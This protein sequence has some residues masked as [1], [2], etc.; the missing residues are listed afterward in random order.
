MKKIVLSIF[1][2]FLFC[3]VKSAQLAGLMDVKEYKLSN[4]M[5]VWLN[6]D[7]LQ[8]KIFGAVLVKAGSKDCPNTGI[9]H[10]FEHMMFKG[11]DRIGTVNYPAEKVLLD[12]IAVKYDE[13][14][15]TKDEASRKHLQQE[16][17]T[18]S[19]HA[20][21]FAIPNEFN[22]LISRF[23]GSNL[24]AGTSFDYTVYYN[25]F[26]PQY[27]NQWAEL[28]SER[29]LN[30]VF[31]L[32]QSE[33]ETVYEEKNMGD[34]MIG[35]QAMDKILERFFKPNPYA[36]PI[37]GSSENLKNPQLSQMRNFFEEYYVAGNMGL[38]LS[39][40]FNTAEILPVLEKTFSRIRSGD[41]P[42][43]KSIDPE[44]FKGVETFTVKYPVPVIK[45]VGIGWRGAPANNA[46]EV[47][48]R[49]ITGLLNNEN[50]TGYL[51]KLTVDGKVMMA[52]AF[53][54]SL[55][56]A[57]VVCVAAIP[58]I[59][60][61]SVSQAKKRIMAE[62]KR[63][64]NGDFT[65]ESFNSLKLEQLRNCEKELENIDSRSQKMLSLFSQGK[66][67]NDY[68]DEIQKI[69]SLTKDDVVKVANKYFTENYL[70]VKKKTGTYPKN[71]LQKPAFAPII[72]KN[73]EVK[74]EY[75]RNLEKMETLKAH[76]RYLDF[77][78]D[79]KRVQLTSMA[80]LY[81]MINPVNDIFTLNLEFGKG[82]MESK[83]AK[84]AG[85]YLSLLGTD[86]LS[87][88]QFREK[89]QNLGSTL[90]F[91]PK[92]D[93]F[94]VQIS[95]FD[96]N[97]VQTLSLVGN[98]MKHVKADPKKLKKVVEIMKVNAKTEKKS[99][100]VLANA[101]LDKVRYGNQSEYLNRLSLSEFQKLK[102]QDL[103]DEFMAITKVQCDIHYCGNLN[104]ETVA[105]EIRKNFA[106]EE[107]S[108]KSQ[109]PVYLEPKIN[110]MPTVYFMDDP[111]SSQSIVSEYIPGKIDPDKVSRY[112][113]SLF[114]H[115]F[116][117]N[118]SSIL[119][120]QIREYRSLA[121]SVSARYSQPTYNHRDKKGQLIARLSTQC[122][123]TTDAMGILDSLIR[124]M[125]VNS[126]RVAT[127]IQDVVNETNNQYPSF[128]ECSSKIASYRK[129]GYE[130]DPNKELVETVAG[131]TID[132]V[133][134]FYDK[135]IIGQP[136]TYVVV[137]NSK[138]I[139]MKKLA[140]F[141][142]IVKVKPTE[143]LK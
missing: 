142:K 126:E 22:R 48:L 45:V 123:K 137:G 89:L 139:N 44:P 75:A 11:T 57:G 14:A 42:Q 82:T 62:V 3:N 17:N 49:I 41:A 127:A 118:M 76:P 10:Y 53:S 27:I 100:D 87:Y 4:G 96:R 109:T 125:P 70:Q 108:I 52:L 13:L 61:Q 143:V 136:L 112:T 40:D 12:S 50:S 103:V 1:I 33:L 2:C 37:I 120:Q 54:E 129:V 71:R 16:I 43:K 36:Y 46:D 134:N 124:Q 73:A 140:T 132:N 15:L 97:F 105:A 24:N 35:R 78:N 21:D 98:F 81:S 80:T 99:P 20:A 38:V 67:W 91:N 86:S 131:M 102:G 114:N 90:D 138:Q 64:R 31:R 133:V 122:D 58:K 135:N 88:N 104:S 63:I 29:L 5:T 93:M 77:D 18:L 7:H 74:S 6:E 55:N 94:V 121:Y 47:V 84:P 83:L 111:K 51:D 115:Y 113:T 39:G 69:K 101:L 117:E 79:V 66:S 59:L 116:G 9:A 106:L 68:L 56:D 110:E 23:G 34:D 119:F 28:Y 65:D 128:R 60:V 141:G 85:M 107:I 19:V 8:P 130:T 92:Q 26:S 95:G 72:P 32:F 25:E 30:P